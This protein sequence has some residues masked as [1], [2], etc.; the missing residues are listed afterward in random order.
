MSHDG[1]LQL[2]DF[3]IAIDT[4]D[5][6]PVGRVGTLDYMVRSTSSGASVHGGF[7]S[8]CG[9][10]AWELHVSICRC[11]RITAC[12]EGAWERSSTTTW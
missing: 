4:R 6:L 5:E 3:G 11:E 7:G 10:G 12:R 9:F 1:K 2:A 8:A